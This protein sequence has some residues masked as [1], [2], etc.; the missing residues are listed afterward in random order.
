MLKQV[1]TENV[2]EGMFEVLNVQVLFSPL[3]S[4]HISGSS[5][6]TFMA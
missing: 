1:S 6:V 5:T 2:G 4:M 3:L